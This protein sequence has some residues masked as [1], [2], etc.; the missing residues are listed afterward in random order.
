MIIKLSI[1][2]QMNDYFIYGGS[3]KEIK[4]IKKILKIKILNLRH[5]YPIQMYQ[6]N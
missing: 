2:D 4:T 5:I 1:L 6:R 3:Y